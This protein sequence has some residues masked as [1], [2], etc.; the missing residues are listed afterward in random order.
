MVIILEND[1]HLWDML[2]DR[3]LEVAQANGLQ[4]H[5]CIIKV[6]NR[7]LDKNDFHEAPFSQWDEASG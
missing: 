3:R 1:G 2:P 5:I 4:P 7:W 6:L